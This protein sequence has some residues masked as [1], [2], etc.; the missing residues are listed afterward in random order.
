MRNILLCVQQ[1]SHYESAVRALES[2]LTYYKRQVEQQQ[3]QLAASRRA[4]SPVRPL[5]P[6]TKEKVLFNLI[7][8][9]AILLRL[10]VS[11]A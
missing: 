9:R 2:E 3:A 10:L 4:R 8:H 1:V 5:S 6:P 7:C 11:D